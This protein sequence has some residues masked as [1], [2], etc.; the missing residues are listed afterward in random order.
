MPKRFQCTFVPNPGCIGPCSQEER[1]KNTDQ[2]ICKITS[3]VNDKLPI[4]CVGS[5]AIQKLYLLYQYF[6]IFAN[7][8]SKK[9]KG[10]INYIEICSGPGRCVARSSRQEF[11]GTALSVILSDE[12]IN[13]NKALFFDINDK[14]VNSLNNRLSSLS[15]SNAKAF[16]GD[17]T[18]PQTILQLIKAE[19]NKDSLNLVVIDPTDC[20][21]PFSFIAGIQNIIPKMDLIMNVAVGTDYN[22]CV[23]NTLQNPDQYKKAIQ[24]YCSFLGDDRFYDKIHLNDTDSE[25]RATFLDTFKH[26]LQSIGFTHFDFKAVENFYHILFATQNDRGIDFWEK[27]T[28]YGYDGQGSLF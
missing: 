16:I 8:M 14:V 17:Y 15:I 20:S 6:A 5:W 21:V 10:K 12:F 27:A 26:S 23:R 13:I 24:K 11:D 3:S 28:K 1:L 7:G 2:D 4:R 25:L 22:R 19:L 9:W 18:K